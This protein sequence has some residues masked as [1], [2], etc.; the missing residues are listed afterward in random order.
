DADGDGED[1][2]SHPGGTDCDDTDSTINTLAAE[3]WYDG[4][5]QDCDG[6]S[7]FDA[8]GD[9]YD[10]EIGG[11]ADC[12]D[13]VASVH[14]GA[15]ES[16]NGVDDD[17]DVM[18]DEDF[19]SVGDVIVTE[20][21]ADAIGSG[22]DGEWFEVYNTTTAD[23]PLDGW[24]LSES[25]G[26][27]NS[28][29]VDAGTT[30]A[31]GS[32]FVFCYESTSADSPGAA[33]DYVYPGSVRLA[34]SGGGLSISAASEVDA[35]NLTGFSTGVSLS[36]DPSAYDSTSND[37]P[38]NWCDATSTFGTSSYGTPGTLNDSCTVVDTAAVDTAAVD[39]AAG[40]GTP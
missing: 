19:V 5:D 17:C 16:D 39:T 22:N 11:G 26:S 40:T 13:S 36:L 7:D 34:N 6:G 4:I 15:T 31:A 8:D 38:A 35:I 23:I 14:P 37:D 9:S 10:A 33:C 30:I 25:M 32:H 21:M 2:D 12:D 29:T 18:I 28:F 24:T 20:V 3:I 1:I 27:T